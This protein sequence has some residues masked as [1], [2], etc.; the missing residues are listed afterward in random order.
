MGPW[1]SAQWAELR[2]GRK[3]LQLALG[4]VEMQGLA[5]LRGE[6]QGRPVAGRARVRPQR[7]CGCHSGL[8]IERWVS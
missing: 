4:L 2:R 5:Q 6:D 1:L 3:P 7:G 8:G